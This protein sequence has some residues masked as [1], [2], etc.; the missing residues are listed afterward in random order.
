[1]CV[2]SGHVT[3]R[4]TCKDHI[5]SVCD[6]HLYKLCEFYCIKLMT[7]KMLKTYKTCCCF[8]TIRIITKCK[9]EDKP[10]DFNQFAL[11]DHMS[12]QGFDKKD[13]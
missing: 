12:A 1:M 3:D 6:S 7:K 10:Q 8:I 11:R 4:A 5:D 9:N 13:V 2:Y